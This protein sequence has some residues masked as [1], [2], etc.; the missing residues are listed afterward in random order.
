MV[1]RRK[2]DE[3]SQ[4]GLQ[5]KCHKET[6]CVAILNKNDIFFSRLENWNVEQVLSGG[7]V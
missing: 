7:R 3:M 4:F 2:I 5:W 1:E 6:P